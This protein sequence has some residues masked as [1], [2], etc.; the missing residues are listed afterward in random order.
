MSQ[1]DS[2]K[3]CVFRKS[4]KICRSFPFGREKLRKSVRKITKNLEKNIKNFGKSSKNRIKVDKS[5]QNQ[6]K[7]QK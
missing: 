3:V 2:I 5:L 4:L 7:M 1:N 6:A